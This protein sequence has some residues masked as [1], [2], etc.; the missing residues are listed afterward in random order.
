MSNDGRSLSNFRINSLR[1]P[2]AGVCGLVRLATVAVALIALSGGAAAQVKQETDRAKFGREG[3]IKLRVDDADEEAA[4]LARGGLKVASYGAFSVIEAPIDALEAAPNAEAL[5]MENLIRLNAGAID[6]SLAATKQLRMPVAPF[7]GKSMRLIQFAG[8]IQPEWREALEKTGATIVTYI[9][10]NAYLIFGDFA[11]VSAA[12]KLGDELSA[13]QWDGDYLDVYKVDPG[14]TGADIAPSMNANTTQLVAIQLVAD[15]ATNKATT[16]IIDRVK[17]AAVLNSYG[18]LNYQNVIVE[19]P[20][21]GVWEVAQQPDVV[22]IQPYD[23]PSHFCERQAQIVAG[24]LSGNSPTA[25][26]YLAW[27]GTKGFT[28]AQ[29]TA[30]GFAVDISDSG[31]DNGTT[32]PNHFGLYEG[33]VR[34]GTSRII[35]NRVVGTPNS[36]STLK[37]CDGHGTL[38]TH[39]IG[40][41]SNLTGTPFA[42]ASGFRYGLG[43][44][45][46]VRVGS[47]VIFDPNSFTSPNYANLQS[48]AYRDSARISSNSWGSL[49]SNRYTTDSQSYDALV[50]DAQPTGSTVPNAGNQEMVIVFANGNAGSA[51]GTVRSPGTAKNVIS[52][53]AAENVQSFGGSDGCG[54]ADS[55]ANSAN[56][57][58]SFSS[59][60]P[61][62]DGRKKPDI[63]APG[64]HVSGGVVQVASPAGTGTADSCFDGSGVCGGVASHYFPSSGQQFYT[65]S[66]GTSHSTP[67]VAGGCALIRQFFINQ[68]MAA[69]SPAMT[70]ALLMNSARYMTG[71]GANDTLWSNNQGMGE[72]NLGEVFNR[73]A[74]TPTVFRDQQSADMFTAT[75]QTRTFTGVVADTSKPFRVTLGWTDAPGATSGAAY[76]NNLDLTV[77]VGGNTYRGNVFSGATSTTGGTADAADNVESVFL[78]A[79]VSGNFTVTITAA[80]IVSDGVPN[81]GG[82]TDQD[83]ALV[84]YNGSTGCPTITVSPT[85]VPAGVTSTSYS[86]TLTATGGSGAYTWSVQSGTLPNGIT[87]STGGLLAG[88]PTASGNF[89]F[90]ALATDTN[91]CTGTRAYTLVITPCEPAAPTA[92]A[93]TPATI[94]SAGAAAL[95][96][97]VPGGQTIDWYTGSCGGTLVPGGANPTV[98]PTVTTTYFAR[99]R[100]LTTGCVSTSCVSATVTVSDSIAPQITTCP[101]LPTLFTGPGA[102]ACTATLGDYRGSV[103]AADNC[104]APGSLVIT[105]SPVPGTLVAN[106]ATVTFTATDASGNPASCNRTISV[107]D[108]TPPV[109]SQCAAPVTLFADGACG[110]QMPNLKGAIT[111]SDNCTAEG[112]LQRSQTPAVG[113]VLGLGNTLVTITVMDAAGNPASCQTSVTVTDN[114]D[115][116][117]QLCAPEQVVHADG[118]GQ[119]PLPDLRA[120]VMATDN[121]GYTIAQSPPPGTLLAMGDTLVTLTVSDAAGHSQQCVTTVHVMDSDSDN[122]PDDLDNCPLLANADQSD[123]DNDGIGDACDPTPGFVAIDTPP[124]AQSVCGGAAISLSVAASGHG[125]LSYQWRKGGAAIDG[126]TA[127]TLNISPATAADTGVYDVV[128]TNGCGTTT[129][130]AVNVLVTLKGDANCDGAVNNFDIDGFVQALLDGQAAWEAT[131]PCDFLCANDTNS[132]AAVNN[133]DIDGFVS[134]I[135]DGCP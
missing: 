70:K 64:T 120:Q 128:I 109:I 100:N 85:S 3:N 28:Q 89:N 78:A 88:I 17:S 9:P 101:T 31:V 67:C 16:A 8:P 122:Q 57:I 84:I 37:G 14:L 59:R 87:L 63:V 96:A 43:I 52:V 48:M 61:C 106:G 13:V 66:S 69:P 20:L 32:S 1:W 117:I 121:C 95:S 26:G 50:R 33:G 46:F 80:N 35:Y 123:C 103:V 130:A 83:F 21:S 75:G 79:G 40:G 126:A 39:I 99:A 10:S 86:Q 47:S 15:E 114:L 45:P 82:S 7:D 11:A 19:M 54:T 94:C 135:L 56:D 49:T 134:C 25:P 90:T 97:T 65:A 93:A 132:D 119:F 73:G 44:A 116:A 107:V 36:G 53:G 129:S 92:P 77:A 104:T 38:N 127:A 27:L 74:V 112:A 133:F 4:L 111:V 51:A 91:S 81:T 105:Q 124:T 131:Y 60:G 110:A 118:N 24:N 125:S 6:T 72:M 102:T 58:A 41:Y 115:V 29:F 62:P 71:S 42:D 18:I 76:N 22:S 34:P 108:N 98:N 30:S 23:L 68:G 5:P 12:A 55:G 113:T 2:R